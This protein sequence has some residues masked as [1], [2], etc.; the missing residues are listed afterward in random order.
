MGTLIDPLLQGPVLRTIELTRKALKCFTNDGRTEPV[1]KFTRDECNQIL[2]GEWL[3]HPPTNTIWCHPHQGLLFVC[4]TNA[5]LHLP[6]NWMGICTLAFLIPQM[7]IV[8]NNWT[9]AIPLTTHR[10]SK[11]A[12]QFVP[13]TNWSGDFSHEIKRC[14]LLG[15]K[16]A[17]TL[18]CQQR[19]V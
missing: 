12:I 11:R 14:L 8:L 19:S 18:L 9:L 16:K 2:K 15:R 4:G 1:G 5:Y 7:N 6:I 17:E 10:Q 3:T 13:P